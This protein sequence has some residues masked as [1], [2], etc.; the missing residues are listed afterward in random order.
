MVEG[1]NENSKNEKNIF[2]IILSIILSTR[3]KKVFVNAIVMYKNF[4]SRS[5]LD[6]KS[7]KTSFFAIVIIPH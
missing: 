1:N 7:K 5:L 6:I 4:F 3:K 2:E